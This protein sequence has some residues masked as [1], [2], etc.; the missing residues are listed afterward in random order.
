MYSLLV[1][2]RKSQFLFLQSKVKG[3]TELLGSGEEGWTR[4]A[5]ADRCLQR[6][7]CISVTIRR[8]MDFITTAKNPSIST[9]RD[10]W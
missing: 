6:P 8:E 1:F 10:M 2:G 4:E 5:M 3:H 7:D 9:A